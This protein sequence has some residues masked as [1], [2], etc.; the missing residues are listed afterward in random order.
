[1]GSKK[2][3]VV[4]CVAST[5]QD[6]IMEIT[7]ILIIFLT[8]MLSKGVDSLSCFVGLGNRSARD[9]QP[10]IA[11]PEEKRYICVKLYGGGMGDQI[12]RYCEKLEPEDYEELLDNEAKRAE[13]LIDYDPNCIQT[14]DRGRM[15]FICRCSA[16]K[17]NSG[18]SLLLSK[19]TLIL[20]LVFSSKFWKLEASAT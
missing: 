1:M 12:K 11:C 6:N 18:D 15:V 19:F 2:W 7:S 17:C 14:Q 5:Q 13:D 4:G 9:R 8:S 16:N 3:T 20:S 10:V